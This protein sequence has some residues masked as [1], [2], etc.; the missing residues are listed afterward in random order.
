[1][2]I[3][4]SVR[5]AGADEPTDLDFDQG[6]IRIGRGPS[7]DVRLP[8]PGVSAI[9]AMVLLDRDRYFLVDVGS[10][11][12]TL[13]NGEPLVPERRK[14]L[15]SGDRVEIGPFEV[16]FQA[17]V[18]MHASYSQERTVAA[19]RRLA[20]QV[21]TA[22]GLELRRPALVVLGG[23]QEGERFDLPPSPGKL[24]VGRS[25]ACS[26]T[27]VDGEASRR[28][29]EVEV[30]PEGVTVRDLGG[31]NPLKVN[32]RPVLRA[33]IHDRDEILVGSTLLAFDEPVE[34]FLREMAERPEPEAGAEVG[35]RAG[36]GG[37]GADEDPDEEPDGEDPTDASR[38]GA[39]AAASPVP[40]RP[41]GAGPERRWGSTGSEL[42]VLLAGALALA[43]C[44][45]AL[46]WLFR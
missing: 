12:G 3:R 42:A 37:A 21:M 41:G 4:L 31:K 7:C 32:D 18:A 40:A 25:S 29:V 36:A 8:A 17:G 10:R 16:G 26:V 6:R 23:P 15:R 19:A 24:D 13:L 11:N 9:H 39:P 46:V 33:R 14:L 35:A 34:A 1:M 45:A 27:L 38:E 5:P 22:G 43:A 28:H 20:E 2:A 44:V 30:G